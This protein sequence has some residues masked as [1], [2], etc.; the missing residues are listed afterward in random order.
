MA[1]PALDNLVR[2]LGSLPGIG[3]RSALRIAFHILKS[4][5]NLAGQLSQA[6]L[7]IRNKIKF[8]AFCGGLTDEEVCSICRN[9][10][11][12]GTICLVE[13]PGDIIAI[14]S[15]GEFQ[16][17]YHVLMGALSPLDGIGPEDLRIPE[18]EERLKAGSYKEIFIATN[19][20]LEGDTT[21]HYIMERFRDRNIRMTRISHGIPTG[22][23]IEYA[24]RNALARSI[25]GR[26]ELGRD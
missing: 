10:K 23:S 4:D 15:T 19:P 17:Q 25:R 5:S 3:Q 2:L 13:E 12:S 7:E 26:Q 22:S 24:D 1:F 21:A 14:E 11:R 20:T 18:L 9:E 16:G 8:C 6:I